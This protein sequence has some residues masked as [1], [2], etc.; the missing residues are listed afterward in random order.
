MARDTIALEKYFVQLGAVLGDLADEHDVLAEVPIAVTS[1]TNASAN[2]KMP[3][4][5]APSLRADEHVQRSRR[6]L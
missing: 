1:V 5:D 3:N 6:E 4:D 2:M